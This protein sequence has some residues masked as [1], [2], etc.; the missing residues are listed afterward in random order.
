MDRVGWVDHWLVIVRAMNPCTLTFITFQPGSECKIP[1]HYGVGSSDGLDSVQGSEDMRLKFLAVDEL[2]QE[3]LEHQLDPEWSSMKK[4]Q[5]WRLHV[6]LSILVRRAGSCFGSVLKTLGTYLLWRYWQNQIWLATVIGVPN[7]GWNWALDLN[8]MS[9]TDIARVGKYSLE[10]GQVNLW[11]R[12]YS[13]EH[14][15]FW[16]WRWSTE[17][18][19]YANK[20][21]S[22]GERVTYRA[23]AYLQELTKVET[24]EVKS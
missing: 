17:I 24:S 9:V 18:G 23:L 8:M 3:T 20:R 1:S 13:S 6:A 14:W 21:I 12:V 19:K 22:C 4:S 5:T 2:M 16:T 15:A 10:S 7:C 11:V